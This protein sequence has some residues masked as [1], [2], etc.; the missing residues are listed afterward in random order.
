MVVVLLGILHVAQ[1]GL[2]LT[3]LLLPLLGAGLTGLFYTLSLELLFKT[4]VAVWYLCM[5]ECVYMPLHAC[6]FQ[7]TAFGESVEKGSLCRFSNLA[8]S[9]ASWRFS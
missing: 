6:E 7:R 8:C 5:N 2:K 4:I 9:R 1:A 3:I